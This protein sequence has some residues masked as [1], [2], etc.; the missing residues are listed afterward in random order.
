[1]PSSAD[2]SVKPIYK[3]IAPFNSFKMKILV[4]ANHS[5]SQYQFPFAKK[6]DL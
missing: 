2:K 1:M 6:Y 4:A 3:I 5:Y